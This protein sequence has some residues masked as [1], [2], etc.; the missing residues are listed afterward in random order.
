ML[1]HF[2]FLISWHCIHPVRQSFT[3]ERRDS[4]TSATIC[5]F[6]TYQTRNLS[7]GTWRLWHFIIGLEGLQDYEGAAYVTKPA[8]GEM[9][10]ANFGRRILHIYQRRLYILKFHDGYHDHINDNSIWDSM[11]L[12]YSLRKQ[13]TGARW[14]IPIHSSHDRY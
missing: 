3:A 2:F 11:C 5:I 12:F 9:D 13:S 6:S 10:M 4:S 8:F 14:L 1:I 7:S